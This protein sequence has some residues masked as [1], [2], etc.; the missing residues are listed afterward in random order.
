MANAPAFADAVKTIP[1]LLCT[2]PLKP[3]A[4]GIGC[5][6]VLIDGTPV[7]PATDVSTLMANGSGEFRRGLGAFARAAL[8]RHLDSGQIAAEVEA[9]IRKIQAAG[10][11]LSHLDA[12]KHVH[13]FPQVLSPL[14][15]AAKACSVRAVRNPFAPVRPLAFAHLVRRPHL[16]KTY[17]EVKV[18]RYWVDEFR[19]T[20]ADAGMVT[21]DGTFGILSTGAL[22]LELFQAIVGGIPEGT[23]EFCCHPGYNDDALA[24]VRTRLRASREREREV[25]TSAAAHEMLEANEIELITYW[26]LQ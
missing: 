11:Q 19:Q 22:D 26:E 21:T 16:W 18:L 5:H 25:L 4:P 15:A 7:L 2:G 1:E 10:V 14:L 8:V 13:L 23:W 17:S 24:K 12:H 6:A 3:A 9:Q 20:V